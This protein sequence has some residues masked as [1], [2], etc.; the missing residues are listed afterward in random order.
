MS[1]LEVQLP[2]LVRFDSMD[3]TQF[4]KV[5]FTKTFNSLKVSTCYSYFMLK[6]TF[7]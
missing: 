4:N 7:T 1:I 2:F 3:P 6:K 5:G